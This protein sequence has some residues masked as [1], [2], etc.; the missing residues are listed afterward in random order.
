M[1]VLSL[2]EPFATLIKENK[3]IIETRSWSTKYRGELYIHASSTKMSKKD[4]ENKELMS[5]IDGKNLNFGN[6]IC[7]CNLVDCIYMTKEYVEDM[8]QNNYQEYICGIYEEGRYAWILDEIQILDNPIKAKGQLGIWD[9]YNEDEIMN[10][11]EDIDYGWIDKNGCI[12]EKDFETFSYDYILQS[13]KEVM[14]NKIGVCWDQ[15]ELERYYFKGNDW[16][17]KTYFLVHYDNDKCPTHTF[18]TF[19]KNNKFYW[20]EHSYKLFK[21]IHEYS[22]LKELLLDV[23]EKFIK[24]ELDNKYINANLVL[25]EYKKPKYSI[26]VQEFYKHCDYGTYIDLDNM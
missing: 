6:I 15:V 1:K 18:L 8:K 13:P 7:K 16:N 9:Y 2:T 24:D 5:L 11:I 14:K 23:R 25:H 12:H 4:S 26:G 22:S 17:I 10:L 3:K 21:G 20:F 19:E